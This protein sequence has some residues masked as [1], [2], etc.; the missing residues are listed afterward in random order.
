VVAGGT[1][2]PANS[3]VIVLMGVSG[4]G[5]STTGVRLA[6]AL[7]WPFRD[8]DS[9]HPPGNIEKMRRGV[10][11]QDEDRWPWLAAI[12]QWIDERCAAGEAAVVSCSALKRDY[13]RRIIGERECVRLVYL[14]GSREL[15]AE[16]ISGRTGHFMPSSL[17]QSQF[18]ALQE[19]GPDER[20]IVVP[21]TFSPKRVVAVIIAELG[22]RLPKR[23]A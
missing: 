21:V 8:A 3:P 10:A 14:Q 4:C 22:L 2:S 20:P 5:K 23:L 6:T 17:L 7:G 18:A 9:F 15:I 13:R 12:A 16:R 1:T 11:L 19:P